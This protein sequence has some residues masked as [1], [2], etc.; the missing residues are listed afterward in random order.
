MTVSFDEEFA[1]LRAF[2]ARIG[3]DPLLTQGA[4]GNTSIK[5][6]DT[7]RIKAS[8]TWLAHAQ[9]RDTFVPVRYRPLLD[10]VVAHTD[11]AE[12]AQL[13]TVAEQNPAGLRPSIE[14]VVHAVLPQRVVVHVHCVDTIA[15]AVRH[16]P[17]PVLSQ[18]LNGLK[19]A[20]VP[21]LRPGLPL[22]RGILQHARG[23]PDVLVLGN[24]GLVVATETVAEAVTLLAE[25]K[26]RLR[27]AARSAHAPDIDRLEALM[28][29]DYRLP[30][31]PEAHA[32][33]TD[34]ASLDLVRKG[35]LYPDHVIFLGPGS[36]VAH[37]N[38]TADAV[39]TRLGF[40]PAAILFPGLGIL[41]RKDVTVA[42]D[43]MA[44]C[45]AHVAAR[46]PPGSSVR[47]LDA[48]E[49][50]ELIHWEAEKYRQVL[51]TRQG[52]A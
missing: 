22:A 3:G 37:P 43:A 30:E 45:L 9:Q 15:L 33:A 52:A 23:R 20:F 35:S 4:G 21:Y 29:A 32:V 2:S 24:H 50:H 1:A 41:M 47:Y 28:G 46:V 18:L 38:E 10:A 51:D 7:L 44:R 8:G 34:A 14:T 40:R 36:V 19:W 16:D 11:E 17:L 26:A 42:A 5:A 49:N 13:F 6:D 25:V 48:A 31:F 12:Q 39:V 27:Q